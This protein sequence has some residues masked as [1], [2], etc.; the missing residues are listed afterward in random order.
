MGSRPLDVG[1]GSAVLVQGVLGAGLLAMWCGVEAVQFN[2]A[3]STAPLLVLAAIGSLAW[4][5][6]S[7]VLLVVSVVVG[8]LT[9][10]F[11]LAGRHADTARIAVQVV[12]HLGIGLIGVGTLA[13]ASTRSPESAPVL[14]VIG[15]IV[16]LPL[17]YL[18][19]EPFSALSDIHINPGLVDR[20]SLLARLFSSGPCRLGRGGLSNGHGCTRRRVPPDHF[21]FPL[22]SAFWMALTI[23]DFE[24]Y[25]EDYAVL[26]IPFHVM[27]LAIIVSVMTH[28]CRHARWRPTVIGTLLLLA[29]VA[30]RYVDLFENL[31][32]RGVAF[33]VVGMAIVIQGLLYTRAKRREKRPASTL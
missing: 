6:R 7:R 25:V 28:G 3:C 14:T 24:E 31:F 16:V 22:A 29:Y 20:E 1:M 8:L 5:Q 19:Y 9:T 30:A 21:L 17:L 2:N 32:M 10:G 33:V 4:R 18:F 23:F 15:R 13:R 11:V 26:T 12:F 27:L